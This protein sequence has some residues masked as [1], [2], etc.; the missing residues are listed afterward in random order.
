VIE[1]TPQLAIPD[2]ELTF[3]TARSSGPGGQNVNKVETRVTLR[4]DLAAPSLAA[5][6]EE[7]RQLLAERLKTRITKA[8][9]LQVT[10]QRH[11]TQSENREAAIE[12][13]VELLRAALHR[14]APRRPTRKPRAAK[15]RRLTAKRRVGAKKDGRRT[16]PRFD[17]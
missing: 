16:P 15:E 3:V 14:E 17:D 7:Q 4:F 6:S 8:G 2:E 9:V 11:R 13:F 12:R 10:S 1:I 5:L